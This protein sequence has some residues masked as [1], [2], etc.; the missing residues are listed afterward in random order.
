MSFV[1]IGESLQ[2]SDQKDDNDEQQEETLIEEEKIQGYLVA[3]SITF[4]TVICSFI[5]DEKQMAH[6]AR[7]EK[8]K[9]IE[10]EKVKTSEEHK[11][12]VDQVA[13]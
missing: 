13:N 7:K 3:Q 8:K 4:L 11:M 10:S 1:S 12:E 5:E 9:Q 6:L 2:E